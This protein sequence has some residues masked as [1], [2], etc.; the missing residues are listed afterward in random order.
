MR[1]GSCKR[2]PKWCTDRLDADGTVRGKTWRQMPSP[3]GSNVIGKV[4]NWWLWKRG[5]LDLRE[6]RQEAR[7]TQDAE[8]HAEEESEVTA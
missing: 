4:L 1:N 8:R 3:S 6:A 5:L 7:A 2:L